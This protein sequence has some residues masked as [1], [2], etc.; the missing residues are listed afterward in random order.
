LSTCTRYLNTLLCKRRISTAVI[1]L[2]DSKN[3]IEDANLFAKGKY[4]I[5]YYW[6][7]YEL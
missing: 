2:V 5:I 6:Q 3:K 7:L 4:L 1:S